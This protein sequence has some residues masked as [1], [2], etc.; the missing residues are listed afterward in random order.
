MHFSPAQTLCVKDLP[1]DMMVQAESQIKTTGGRALMATKRVADKG[2]EHAGCFF[3]YANYRT[4]RDTIVA[5]D[6]LQH[7]IVQ[8]MPCVVEQHICE[9]TCS[10]F[11]CCCLWCVS[12][13]FW[14]VYLCVE[15]G[16]D[17]FRRAGVVHLERA[18]LRDLRKRGT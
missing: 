17:A 4:Q 5:R 7:W 14:G 15:W 1:S 3:L 6:R 12:V 10:L 8:E 13:R 11:G 2:A 9:V 18:L 16:T